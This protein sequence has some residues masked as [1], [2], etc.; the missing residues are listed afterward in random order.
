MNLAENSATREIPAV[1]QLLWLYSSFIEC[2]SDRIL[3]WRIQGEDRAKR[4]RLMAAETQRNGLRQSG[5]GALLASQEEQRP[6]Q[7]EPEAAKSCAFAEL[8]ARPAL[9]NRVGRTKEK[10]LGSPP[11][12]AFDVAVAGP[13]RKSGSESSRPS[14]SPWARR[15]LRKWQHRH[16]DAAG[17]RP[18]PAQTQQPR[19]AGGQSVASAPMTRRR[20]AQDAVRMVARGH[21]LDRLSFA[22]QQEAAAVVLHGLLSVPV[23]RGVAARLPRNE[24]FE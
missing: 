7:R 5:R 15:G 22:G 14:R 12:T 1:Q 17:A 9:T 13:S 24:R 21:G 3:L 2:P 16:P 6:K 23:P 8:G 10:T 4:N 20:A 18:E 19:F 11:V